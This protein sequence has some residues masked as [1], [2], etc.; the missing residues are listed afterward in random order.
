MKTPTELATSLEYL[1]EWRRKD[2]FRYG[3]LIWIITTKMPDPY[4]L[5]RE[6][7]MAVMLLREHAKLEA[8]L[9]TERAR[10]D[11]VLKND[12]AWNDRSEIDQDIK[13]SA[14]SKK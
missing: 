10:L 4:E 12:C 6:I 13:N 2:E 3:S 9:T 1:N 5:G 11:Y 7:D 8:A 14:E